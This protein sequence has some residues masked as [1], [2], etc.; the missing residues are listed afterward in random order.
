MSIHVIK[1]GMFTTIQDKGRKGYQKYGVLTSGG[2]D[3]LSLRIANILT[4]NEEN[5]AVLEITLMGP[6]PVLTCQKDELIGLTGA[7]VEIDIDGEPAP[8][9]KPLFVRS[10]STITFGPCKR[11]CRAY[12]AV[13]GGFDVEPVMQSKSTYVRAGIG[14]LN[15]R[16]LEKGDVLSSGKPS[17]VADRLSDRLKSEV[18]QAAYSAPDW[19]VSHTHFLPLRKSP[20]IRVLPG[21]HLSFFQEISQHTFF[22][23]PYQVTPQSD[24]MGCRLKG[25]PVHLKE[26]LELI[27]EAVAFGSIQIPPDGQPIILLADRQT[28]GGYPRIGEVATVDLPLIAQAMPG[29]NLYFKRIHHQDAEQALFKQEAELK[30]LAARIKLEAFV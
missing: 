5:E 27:S 16:P 2:M 7:D 23:Q 24:R 3:P 19:T 1:P 30:E 8:L 11:G 13:A 4:G 28:T 25:E 21:R 12:L 17:I 15:G 18:K 20:V 22:E 14:G 6:G 9:W 10:G 29:A 26:K